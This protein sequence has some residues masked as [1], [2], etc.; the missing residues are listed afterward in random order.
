VFNIFATICFLQL[1]SLPTV[2]I[3][4]GYIAFDFETKEECLLKRN[5]LVYEIN[6]DLINRNISMF[7]TCNP[8]I[9]LESTN[10]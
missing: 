6:Q 8:K 7:L 2:C 3:S 4:N 5:M 10:V 9:S 1:S